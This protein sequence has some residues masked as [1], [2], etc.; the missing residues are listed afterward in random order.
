MARLL[1][2]QASGRKGGYTA[3]IMKE[4]VARLEQVEGLEVETLHL[5]SYRFGPCNSCFH[6][7]RNVGAGCV[8][9]DDWGRKGDG[10]L[11]RAFK[12]ANGWLAVD[13]VHGWGM[14]AMTRV[15][16]ERTY[17]TFWEGV[18]YGMPFASI[19]C[20]SNQGFQLQAIREHCKKACGSGFRWIGGLPVHLAYMDKARPKAI[21]L[22]LRLAEA[23]IADERDGRGKLTDDELFAMYTG[24][25]WDIV[26][27]YLENITDGSFD[28][29]TSVP[30]TALREGTFDVPEGRELLLRVCEHLKPALELYRDG[31]M[32]EAGRELALVAKFWTNA[33]FKQFVEG[34]VVNAPIPKAYRPL[35][36]LDEK[37]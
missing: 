3:S 15:F 30:A 16:F 36:E 14:S 10:E 12:R 25:P 11:Y 6:C 24:T 17:P 9:D 20:A 22:A 13:P 5:H 1:V 2:T 37:P 19:A 29:E 18:P 4:V 26:Y 35:D 32:T 21:A 7:I 33:T 23:A 31:K 34:K 27:G 8:L 28:Y